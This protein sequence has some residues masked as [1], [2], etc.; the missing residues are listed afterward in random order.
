MEKCSG[1]EWVVLIGVAISYAKLLIS[2]PFF[3]NL[4]DESEVKLSEILTFW[5]GAD[6]VPPGSFD[7]DLKIV[8]FTQ[9]INERRLPSSSTCALQLWLPRGVEELN[10]FTDMMKT[11]IKE[12]EGFGKI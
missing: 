11:C 8:F 1:G 7:H 5:T 9:E 6:Q 3:Y 4:G 10:S 12:T 2:V